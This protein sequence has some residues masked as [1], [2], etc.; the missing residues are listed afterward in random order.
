MLKEKRY[1][2]MPGYIGRHYYCANK[3]A[4]IHSISLDECYVVLL[5]EH[6][7]DMPKRLPLVKPETT[8]EELREY[9]YRDEYDEIGIC[10]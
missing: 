1:I 5:E 6:L 3:I 10:D 2:V 9:Q 7:K 4:G 8:R